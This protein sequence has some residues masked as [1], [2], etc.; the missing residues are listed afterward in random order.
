MSDLNLCQFIGRA[1]RDPEVRYTNDGKA[2]CSLTIAV[3]QTWKDKNG[4]KQEETEWVR[5][6]FWDKLA[7][8]AGEYVK[9]GKQVYVSG[10]MKTRKYTDKDGAEKY[11]TE[12]RADQLQLLGGRD[13]EE[14]RRQERPAPRPAPRQPKPSTGFDDM[15]DDVPF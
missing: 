13:Q 3:S 7:E 1:G 12:I 14:P 15:E 10:K 11:V 2:V 6:N 9:K 4:E 5:V 8:I